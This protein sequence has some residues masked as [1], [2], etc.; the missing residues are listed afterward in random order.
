MY[1]TMHLKEAEQT[2][3][4]SKRSAQ[5]PNKLRTGSIVISL[6]V[7]VCL[8]TL[9]TFNAQ[10]VLA[11]TD[12]SQAQ[13]GAGS[14]TGASGATG[15]FGNAGSN[16]SS[17]SALSNIAGA[18][19]ISKKQEV[20]YVTAD[21]DGSIQSGTVVNHFEVEK[22]GVVADHG[23]YSTVENLSTTTAIECNEDQVRFY[24]EPGDFYYSGELASA[25][26]PWDIKINYELDGKSVTAEQLAGATGHLSL[27]INIRQGM[28][29]DM[30]FYDN[31]LLT[32]DVTLPNANIKQLVAK[33]AA[34]SSQGE[35]SVVAFMILPGKDGTLKLEADVS[36][37]HMDRIQIAAVPMSLVLDLPDASAMT[38]DMDKLV[39]AINTLNDGIFKM[40]NSMSQLALGAAKLVDGSSNIKNGL[41]GLS[42]SSDQLMQA[43]SEVDASLIQIATQLNTTLGSD[44]Q[45]VTS[46][47]TANSSGLEQIKQ[48]P[49]VLTQLAAALNETTSSMGQIRESISQQASMLDSYINSIPDLDSSAIMQLSAA[50]AKSGLSFSEQYT[51]SQLIA[52]YQSAAYLKTIWY[53][54]KGDDGIKVGLEQTVFALSQVEVG[55]N[56]IADSL[57]SIG[58]QLDDNSGIASLE[59]SQAQLTQLASAIGGIS[60]GYSQFHGSL[61]AYIGGVDTIATGYK[62]FD[63]G[64]GELF[65]GSNALV[66]GSGQLATGSKQIVVNAVTVP[67]KLRDEI[68]KLSSEY[69]FS[70]FKPASFVSSK[71]ENVS[72][73]Q[74]VFITPAIELPAP[75]VDDKQETQPEQSFFDRLVALFTS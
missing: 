25:S 17:A 22:G 56:Q 65:T 45:I 51:V 48:L 3:F 23:S 38:S 53:G 24:S 12:S 21:H 35:N 60:Q 52:A 40:N 64:I 63:A 72:L 67:Q 14:T 2:H 1:M 59:N 41:N 69:D 10:T 49:E 73:V 46:A 7:A 26:L 37:F 8:L 66:E 29:A 44:N 70:E 16:S 19:L 9:S 55:I 28:F 50:L 15:A 34:I 36:T 71:N 18:A 39:E 27:G 61:G 57:S 75:V 20:V 68:N 33:E 74:F 6:I 42:G 30:R 62:E 11:N 5:K 54:V 47:K 32:V 43:S 31:Y 58:N 13:D 4:A